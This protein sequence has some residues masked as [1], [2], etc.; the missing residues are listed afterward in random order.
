MHPRVFKELGKPGFINKLSIKNQPSCF[1]I[2][3]TDFLA[4]YPPGRG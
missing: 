2:V 4:S 3:K 1:A